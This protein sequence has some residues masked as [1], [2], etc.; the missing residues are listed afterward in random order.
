MHNS[1][2]LSRPLSSEAEVAALRLM[3]LLQRQEDEHT[4]NIDECEKAIDAL[5][6]LYKD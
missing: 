5:L 1:S 4:S 2:Y 3:A 6:V